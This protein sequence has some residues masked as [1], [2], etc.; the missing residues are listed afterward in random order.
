[1]SGHRHATDRVD[2]VIIAECP[3]IEHPHDDHL[4]AV[5]EYEDAVDNEMLELF[6]TAWDTCG[7]CGADLDVM[8]QEEP[9][10]VLE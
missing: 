2:G 7:K 4:K 3:N 8:I 1:M 9:S 5:V 6:R 10:E